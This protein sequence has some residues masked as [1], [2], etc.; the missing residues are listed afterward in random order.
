LNP[1]AI[2]KTPK[3]IKEVK[4]GDSKGTDSSWCYATANKTVQDL[5]KDR[6]IEML[7]QRDKGLKF[8]IKS[9]DNRE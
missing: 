2:F 7:S 1:A 9:A 6:I 8:P 3:I 4:E 5:G